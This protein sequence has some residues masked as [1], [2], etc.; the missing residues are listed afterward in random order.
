[1]YL[2]F[3]KFFSHLDCYI[4]LSR[5]PCVTV[6]YPFC[7]VFY[8]FLAFYFVLEYCRF[9]MSQWFQVNSRGTQPHIHCIHSPPSSS[10][11]QPATDIEQSSVLLVS[12]SSLVVHFNYGSVCMSVPHSLATPSLLCFLCFLSGNYKFIL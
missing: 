2:F 6:G 1:M 10:P 12:R 7:L 11:T 4:I 5:G 3:F 8:F 9:T